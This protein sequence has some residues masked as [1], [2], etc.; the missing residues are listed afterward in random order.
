MMGKTHEVG[1]ICVGAIA[2]AW[3]YQYTDFSEHILIGAP[4]LLYT[5]RLGSLLPDIDHPKSMIGRKVP[6]L[7]NFI[8]KSVGH[9]GAT[10]TLCAMILVA[11]ILSIMTIF[12][13][14]N[15]RLYGWIVVLG[16]T[17]GYLSHLF[18]DTLTPKGIPL[19]APFTKKTIRLAKLT[20]GKYDDYVSILMVI[21]TLWLIH[22]TT[23]F[24]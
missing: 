9:R 17:I 2:T 1:G 16:M 10:H 14:I 12:L 22:S 11:L 4:L 7:S 5:A 21:G 23:P 15:M 24:I 6:S 20:T 13:P 18:L 3:L 19:F 8:N